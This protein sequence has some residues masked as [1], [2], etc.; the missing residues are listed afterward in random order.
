MSGSMLVPVSRDTCGSRTAVSEGFIA[1]KSNCRILHSFEPVPRDKS[2]AGSAARPSLEGRKT[3]GE[4]VRCGSADITRISKIFRM[5]RTIDA[6]LLRLR[7]LAAL[8]AIGLS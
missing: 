5:I 3:G 1:H 8:P 2:T 7:R 6:R 4:G